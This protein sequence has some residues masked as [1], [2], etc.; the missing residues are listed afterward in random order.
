[1]NKTVH[2]LSDDTLLSF[3]Y[4]RMKGLL[5]QEIDGYQL[6]PRLSHRVNIY[7]YDKGDVFNRHVDGDWP[8]YELNEEGDLDLWDDSIISKLTMLIYLNDGVEGGST[9]LFSD[10]DTSHVDIRPEAGSA[11]FFRHGFGQDSVQHQGNVI[12]G[13]NTKYVARMNVM[14]Q[15]CQH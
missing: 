14:Y 5:P 1:M 13:D 6:V 15:A 4:D 7:K 11:L 8:G 10:D 2:W 12:L 3:I 9:R